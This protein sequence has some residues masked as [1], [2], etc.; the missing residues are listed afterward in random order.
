MVRLDLY[1]RT[2]KLQKHPAERL[3]AAT[4]CLTA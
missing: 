3:S 2:G 4:S 1:F